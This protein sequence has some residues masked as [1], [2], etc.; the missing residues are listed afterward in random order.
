M[1]DINRSDLETL[2][3]KIL[4]EESQQGRRSF[5]RPAWSGCSSRRSLG[6]R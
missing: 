5:Y 1:A 4:L 3:R 6:Y 2:V